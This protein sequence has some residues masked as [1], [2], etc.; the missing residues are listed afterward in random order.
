MSTQVKLQVYMAFYHNLLRVVFVF[1]YYTLLLA[2]DFLSDALPLQ[3]T[4][5]EIDFYR[6]TIL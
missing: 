5:T 3:Y 1:I 6:Q 4:S 2:A